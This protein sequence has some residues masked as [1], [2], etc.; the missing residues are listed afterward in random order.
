MCREIL[1]TNE[2]SKEAFL[3]TT[4]SIQ[5][6]LKY[7]IQRCK[8]LKSIKFMVTI[9]GKLKNLHRTFLPVIIK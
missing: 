6:Y 5:Y 8:Y 9:P 1:I 7:N 2:I 4:E 3:L